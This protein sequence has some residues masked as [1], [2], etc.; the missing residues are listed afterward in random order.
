MGVTRSTALVV[1][2]GALLMAAARDLT[3]RATVGATRAVGLAVGESADLM[4]RIRAS[5]A[6]AYERAAGTIA[7]AWQAFRLGIT[8]LVAEV[9]QLHASLASP[10]GSSVAAMAN[11]LEAVRLR[12]TRSVERAVRFRPSV[13]AVGLVLALAFTLYALRGTDGPQQLARPPAP[14]RA[15]LALT[16]LEPTQLEPAQRAPSLSAP[17]VETK[18]V[19]AAPPRID[20]PRH[21]PSGAPPRAAPL[22]PP[23][24]SA[25]ELVRGVASSAPTL[26]SEPSLSAPHVVGRLSAK[27]PG[28]AEREFIALLAGVGGTELGRSRRVSSRRSKWSCRD[29]ATTTSP[30]ASR[31]SAPGGR[32][33]RSLLC[34]TPS[35]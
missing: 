26:L 28:A 9:A 18:T 19:S 20:E 3:S 13:Q 17:S 11:A 27:D 32:R 8:R 5:L 30:R 23:D 33:P 6:S 22:P 35:T 34:P 10:L 24:V 31:A 12:I 25:P 15:G 14:P 2:R 29:P 16:R 21:S 7:S 4:T 1:W